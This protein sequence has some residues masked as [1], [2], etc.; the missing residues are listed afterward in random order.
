MR[1]F[2]HLLLLPFLA[3]P[4]LAQGR[5][6]DWG[7]A[8]DPAHGYRWQDEGKA[9]GLC[10]EDI[11]KLG[12]DKVLLTNDAF[13]QVFEPYLHARVTQ[14]ITS[15]SLLNAFHVL[16]EESILHLE[17]ANAKRLTEVLS[18]LWGRVAP[19]AES[20]QGKP[21]LVAAARRRAQVVLG[22]AMSLLGIDPKSDDADLSKLIAEETAR[23]IAGTGTLKPEWLGPPDPG[24]VA[25]D[26]SRYRP[27]GL[28]ARS[29]DLTRYFRAVSWLQSIP[30]RPRI[31]QELLSVF[32]LGLA[33]H[34][35]HRIGDEPLTTRRDFGP[36]FRC[37]STFVGAGDSWD[38]SMWCRGHDSTWEHLD[39]EGRTV[40]EAIGW[41][42]KHVTEA[43]QDPKIN[44]QLGFAPEAGG[45][46]VEASIRILS[47][48]R[49]PDAVL[50]QRTSRIEGI[51]PRWPTGL[52]VCV[53]L[54]S[55]RA[56]ALL[57]SKDR[58]RVLTEID[59]ARPLFQGNSLYVR[60]LDC[61]RALIDAPEPDA[62][63]FMSTE[64]WQDKSCQTVLSGWAQMRHTWALQ[65]KQTISYLGITRVP[66]GFVEPEPEFF[67]RMAALAERT[68][69]ALTEAGAFEPDF[70]SLARDLRR[71]SDLL[72]RLSAEKNPSKAMR[73]LAEEERDLIL[74]PGMF[75]EVIELKADRSD[76]AAYLAEASAG[77]R[78]LAADLENGAR[79]KYPRFEE[80]L[81]VMQI[82]LRPKWRALERLCRRLEAL[83][84]KQLR[85]VELSA[86]E[87]AFLKGY[88]KE[89]AG[90]MLYGGNSYLTP[91]DDAPRVVDVFASPTEGRVLEVG[92][93][94]PHALWVLY[95]VNGGELLC[96]GAVMPYYEFEHEERL[97]DADWKELL[98]G[99][100]RPPVPGWIGPLLGKD[101]L[102]PE[103][104]R[105]EH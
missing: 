99:R 49:T 69:E 41:S 60:Y 19:I 1:Q 34:P 77:L 15:D 23:V 70:P 2:L 81:E 97:T 61:L 29:E 22:T 17:R 91:R 55:A 30:F 63:A 9:L 8:H 57:Q 100:D 103:R 62:P 98:E 76:E 56:K 58:E 94:R 25:I 6:P 89:I 53:A 92:I 31:E 4:L 44:D 52:E 82:D 37:F 65:A 16:Y 54:G 21:D 42:A 32:L 27:R 33:L 35:S 78:T 104:L 5:E 68:V 14:F 74:G 93:C 75:A 26:Y 18:H 40:A 96:E 24:F 102:T 73:S 84:H 72:L 11:E 13:K 85:H 101:G 51:D 39:L 105:K 48:R 67:A 86:E 47:A 59:A 64:A 50:F 7:Q 66:P 87:E 45:Q 46:P 36:F 88:G 28:Y 38:L 12:R 83:A 95:P 43:D 3:A 71:V 90:L 80:V 10:D 79:S 20:M